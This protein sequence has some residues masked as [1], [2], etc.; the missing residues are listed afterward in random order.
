MISDAGPLIFISKIGK[1]SLLRKLF[2]EIIVPVAVQQ[3][4]LV[5][6]KP[7]YATFQEALVQQWIKVQSPKRI[8]EL[9]LGSGENEAISL[10]RETKDTL[11]LDDAYAIKAAR[12]HEV[13][14]MR[15]TT[16]LFL[17]AH[18]KII[19]PEELIQSINAL[20]DAGYYIRPSEYALLLFKIQ[21][22][23]KK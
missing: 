22:L 5:E 16:V 17:A 19:T 23:S 6:G 14:T 10:A 13:E 7:G 2:K 15:T 3:E 1:L 20:M 12:I 4:V 9:S 18:K 8:I 11:L 21:A